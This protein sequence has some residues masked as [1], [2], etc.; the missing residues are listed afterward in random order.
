MSTQYVAISSA[1]NYTTYTPLQKPQAPTLS[2]SSPEK[3]AV[4]KNATV[5][6]GKVANADKYSVTMKNTETGETVSQNVAGNVL[7]ADFK[8][9]KAGTY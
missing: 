4:G 9:S 2:L 1:K 7:R 5:T 6:W 3:T 8:L